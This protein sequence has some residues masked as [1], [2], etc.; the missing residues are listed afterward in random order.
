MSHKGSDAAELDIFLLLMK[1]SSL[2]FCR[3]GLRKQKEAKLE[4]RSTCW[5]HLFVRKRH[6]DCYVLC[7]HLHLN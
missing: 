1:G 7:M 2:A 5:P 3:A 6:S 4:D